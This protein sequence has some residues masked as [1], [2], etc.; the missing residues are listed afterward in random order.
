MKELE[1]DRV[2]E[3]DPRTAVDSIQERGSQLGESDL[4]EGSLP[5]QQHPTLRLVAPRQH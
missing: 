3:S 2:P 5:A 4:D 1:L